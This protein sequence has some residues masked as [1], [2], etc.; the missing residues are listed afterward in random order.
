MCAHFQLGNFTGLGSEVVKRAVRSHSFSFCMQ[1]CENWRRVLQ[2]QSQFADLGQYEQ[3][4][5]PRSP[6]PTHPFTPTP[7]PPPNRVYLLNDDDIGKKL[8]MHEAQIGLLGRP[9]HM[10]FRLMGLVAN[11]VWALSPL[12]FICSSC[13]WALEIIFKKFLRLLS[14]SKICSCKTDLW[15][16]SLKISFRGNWGGGGGSVC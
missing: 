14:F 11:R 7:T 5:S 16:N 13:V 2:R 3:R 8:D 9:N 4:A 12:N 1:L 15:Y 10:H 6:P